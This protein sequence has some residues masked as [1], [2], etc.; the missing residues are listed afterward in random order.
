V[1]G[2]DTHLTG[3]GGEVD[4]GTVIANLSVSAPGRWGATR[5]LAHTRQSSGR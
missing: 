3:G 4:L 2:K 1:V 5:G